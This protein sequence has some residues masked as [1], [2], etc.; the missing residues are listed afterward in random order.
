MH[1]EFVRQDT[2]DIEKVAADV[3][4]L[5]GDID[6]GVRGVSW[7]VAQSER[8]RRRVIYVPGNHEYYSHSYPHTLDKMRRQAHDTAVYVLDQDEVLLDG[9]RFLGATLWTDFC[10]FGV[11]RQAATMALCGKQMNDYRK[12]RVSPRFRKLRPGDT[13]ALHLQAR[14]W[15]ERKRSEPTGMPTVVVTHT[16]PSVLSRPPQ[17]PLSV[18]AAAYLSNLESMM[19]GEKVT[20]WVH[21]HTHHCVDYTIAGTRVVGNQRGY[22]NVEPVEAFDP[23]FTVEI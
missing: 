7:A 22:L 17:Y 14:R 20:L 19:D 1:N 9:I 18:L 4:V 5:S 21:G 11:E 13:A 2:P 23:T 12:I 6:T 3:I 15:L 8:L 10:L 16:G